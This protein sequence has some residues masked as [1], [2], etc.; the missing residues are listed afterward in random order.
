MQFAHEHFIT[1]GA[2][3]QDS[4]QLSDLRKSDFGNCLGKLGC[5]KIRLRAGLEYLSSQAHWSAEVV[6]QPGDQISRIQFVT[7]LS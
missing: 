4:A 1:R 7:V 5:S 3:A 6:D 2:P